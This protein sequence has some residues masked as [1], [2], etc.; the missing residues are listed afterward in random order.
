[1][2]APRHCD[3]PWGK[4]MAGTGG[5]PV[6]RGESSTWLT[7]L[8]PAGPDRLLGPTGELGCRAVCHLTPT[9]ARLLQCWGAARRHSQ[10]RAGPGR[11]CMFGARLQGE[12]QPGC[13]GLERRLAQV[14]VQGPRPASP[15]TVMHARR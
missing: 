9:A 13:L 11:L 12:E 10:V 7:G 5:V 3:E 15:G 4:D 8:H 2:V 6:H 1:M 14:C